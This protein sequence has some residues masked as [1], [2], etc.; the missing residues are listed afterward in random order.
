MGKMEIDMSVPHCD[1]LSD[2]VANR[3]WHVIFK[4]VVAPLNSQSWQVGAAVAA[5]SVVNAASAQT[6]FSARFT[7]RFRTVVAPV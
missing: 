5:V 7:G 1:P 4:R 6:S 2:E 3:L